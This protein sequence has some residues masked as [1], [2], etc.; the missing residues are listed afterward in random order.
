MRNL[1]SQEYSIQIHWVLGTCSEYY[2]IGTIS[3]R[4]MDADFVIK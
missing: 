3:P 2:I 4:V 1:N